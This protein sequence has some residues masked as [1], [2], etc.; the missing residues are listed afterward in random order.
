MG[1]VFIYMHHISSFLLFPRGI[2]LVVRIMDGELFLGNSNFLSFFVHYSKPPY[3]FTLCDIT[4]MDQTFQNS[5][6][7]H[8]RGHPPPTPFNIPSFPSPRSFPIGVL[9]AWS[10]CVAE[11]VCALLAASLVLSFLGFSSRSCNYKAH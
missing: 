1:R 10:A 4:L 9:R 2:V 11:L 7:F 5:A 6:S 8:S 3:S